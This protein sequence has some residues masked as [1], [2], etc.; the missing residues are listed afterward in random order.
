MY[1]RVGD[2]RSAQRLV[3]TPP[4]LDPEGLARLAL[5]RV[6]KLLS[7]FAPGLP[8]DRARLQAELAT[9]LP[10]PDQEA[11]RLFALGWLRW[12]EGDPVAAEPLFAEALRQARQ[13]APALLAES[14][15]WCGR[16]RVLLGRADAVAEFE[17][18]LRGLAGSP[19][20]T[21]WFVDLLWRAGRVDRAEQVWKS[22][23]GNR[24]V[25]GCDEGPLLEARSL[26]RRGEVLPAERALQEATPAGGVAW[27][28]RWLLLAWALASRRQQEPA[29]EV[30]REA[31]QGPYPAGALD[32]WRVLVEGRARGEVVAEAGPV[33]PALRDFLR[34]Q[35]AR[36]GGEVG[37]AVEAYRAA[38]DSPA[39]PFARYALACL[40]QED[41]AAVLAGQPGLFLAVRCRARVALER[42]RRRQTTPAECLD[43]LQQAAAGGYRNPAADHFRRLAVSLQQ[44][45]PS[46]EEI[47][48]LAEEPAPDDAARRNAFRAALEL[49]VRRLPPGTALDLLLEWARQDIAPGARELRPVLARQLLRL[50]LLERTSGAVPEGRAETVLAA[51]AALTPEE[52]LLPLVRAGF[53][54]GTVVE[55]PPDRAEVPA[56]TRLW[57]AA[58]AL[59]ATSSG[60][61]AGFEGGEPWREAVPSLRG[62]PRLRPLAQVLLLV[63][64][65]H[66]GDTAEV[67]RLL[68][69]VDAWRGFQAGPPRFVLR[70]VEGVVAAQPAHPAWRR[71]LPR[72]LQVWGVASLGPEGA[73]LAAQA[74]LAAG[75]T[76]EPPPGTPAGPWFLHQA[77]RALARDD[78][79]E[80]LAL[81]RRALVLD[82][83]LAGTE[84]AAAVHA[85]LTDLERR[86]RAQALGVLAPA[87]SGAA[88]PLLADAVELLEA[89][90]DG[91]ALLEA[92]ARGER[93][94]A[95]ALLAALGEAPDLPG[96]LAHHLALLE[97]QAAL[98]LEDQDDTE[99]AEPCWRRAWGC[100][101]RYLAGASPGA[102]ADDAPPGAEARAVLL[103]WLLGLH[104]HRVNDLLARNAIDQARRHWALVQELPARVSGAGEALGSELAGRVERF[105]E[106]L[107]TEYLLT[108]REAMR[109]GTIPE[110]WRAD[111]EKGLGYL[112]RLLSLDRDNV[113][114]LSALVEVCT[115]WFLDLYNTEDAPRLREQVERFTPFALQLARL[116]EGRPGDLAARAALADYY[117]F[118]GFVHTDR[119]R[120]VALYREA[121]RF[122][123]ANDNVR[124]LL[125]DLEEPSE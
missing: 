20:A 43:T 37:Q 94:Q 56:A 7:A 97:Q 67:A 8:F 116:A 63:E 55:V 71:S 2:A 92:A 22:V 52:P 73:T 24:R 39:Q 119:A 90:P 107:A 12:L 17:A 98:A 91:Q 35:Q 117:K 89:R 69:E 40:D 13:H 31:H 113:R 111:Y 34:G 10:Q 28:E 41:P 103:D 101:L 32:A 61:G 48:A 80:A 68:E 26:L 79:R 42:F 118:R 15:Y 110:G 87:D 114:L 83:E 105:R 4:G 19:Q 47:Q 112:R 54:A 104:R 108:T 16:A 72:W 53:Q 78:A 33:P 66:R 93:E 27:V 88:A 11:E 123:P 120:K 76:A 49:A 46:P 96:R 125:A 84:G 64:A 121:L 77:A 5:G 99:A 1:H 70:L 81:T 86:A 106:E 60:D 109:Y 57:Q 6:R 14:A 65:A 45:Q 95:R 3:E 122:N 25:A 23:R 62:E 21:A 74:G 115:E 36:L 38:L 50:L 51:A 58:Q 59:A 44:R 82:P 100:W 30:L 124:N 85:A 18:V 75:D 9:A 29:L 102:P